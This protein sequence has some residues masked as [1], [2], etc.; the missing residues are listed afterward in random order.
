MSYDSIQAIRSS[1]LGYLETN[2]YLYSLGIRPTIES[3]AVS[4]GSLVHTLTLEPQDFGN[5]YAI[6]PEFNKRTKQGKEDYLTW[7]ETN[8]NKE[9]ITQ[10]TY[11]K[12]L[13]LSEN[14]KKITSLF[15]DC[16]IEKSFVAD[17][18]DRIKIKAKPDLLSKN[19]L[20]DLKTTSKTDLQSDY[21]IAKTIK[22]RKY[23]RQLGFYKL[24]LEKLGIEIKEA[25]LIFVDTTNYWVRGVRLKEI[26]LQI[27]MDLS[28][29]IIEKY[30]D[31]LE[32]GLKISSLFSEINL[33]NW[34]V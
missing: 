22:E 32:N 9:I 26:D 10:D 12:A 3:K 20:I 30:N 17:Y 29:E 7:C 33:P 4:L 19:I 15:S 27:G 23:H 14:A 1:D 25:I 34:E 13:L 16:E 6:E 2:P 21:S 28:I 18:N 24:V 31:I 11:D 8:K 5:R